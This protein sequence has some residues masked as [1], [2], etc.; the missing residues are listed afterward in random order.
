LLSTHLLGI[1][2]LASFLIL[3]SFIH[4]AYSEEIFTTLRM[5][6]HHTIFDGKWSHTTEWK[7]TSEN[8]IQYDDGKKLAIRTGH[9]YENLYV[10]INFISDTSIQK[11]A[12]YGIVCIDSK[13]NKSDSPDSDDFC[14]RASLGYSNPHTLNGGHF[15]GKTNY[16]KNVQNHQNLASIGGVS[17]QNDR[18]SKIPHATYE[19]K[20]PLEI[21]GKS[22][23]YGFYVG[24][25]DAKTNKMYN[26][27]KNPTT[28]LYPHVSSPTEWGDLISPDK[29]IPE[30]PFVSVTLLFS[31]GLYFF[32]GRKMIYK[33]IISKKF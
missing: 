2:F 20:I 27:P 32:I 16:W 12:D 15:L 13:H 23:H 29:S 6:D 14:F 4:N 7:D 8:V 26:W 11:I 19:F 30:F 31:F 22:D 18:Y 3:A 33:K 17:D 9:D 5:S 25:F 28:K 24:A 21:V 1:V 10:M